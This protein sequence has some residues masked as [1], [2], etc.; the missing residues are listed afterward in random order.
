MAAELMYSS[1]H[2]RWLEH[3]VIPLSIFLLAFLPRAIYPV[4][5]SMLWYERAVHF[6]DALL[7]RDWAGTYLTYH[8]GVTT[9]WLAGIGIKI[10]AWQR[11]LSS[12]QLLGTYPSQI[13]TVNGAIAA[14]VLPLALAI[15][16]CIALSY[17][18]LK[19]VADPKVAIVGSCLLALDPFHITYSKVLHVNALLATF[20]FTSVLYLFSYCRRAKW[21][22]LVLSGV[23]AGLAFLTKSPSFFLMPYVVLVLGIRGL[24]AVGTDLKARS[25]WGNWRSHLWGLIR[26]LLVWI[27]TAAVIFVVVWPA[28]WVKPLDVLSEMANWTFFHVETIHENPIF[29]NGEAEFGDPGVFFYLATIAWKTTAVTLLMSCAALVFA[30]PWFRQKWPGDMVWLLIA[31]VVFFVVQ[32]NLGSWKQVSYMV[33]VFP[34]IGVVA[35][36]GL[37]QS[38]EMIDRLRGERDRRR[39]STLFVLLA[40]AFQFGIVLSHHPY[41]GTHHNNLL[42]GSKVARHI[43]PLQ[44]QGEGLDLAARYLNT[45]PRAQHA[46]AMIYLLGAIPFR[47]S[48]VGF[49]G[50]GP[51]PWI[52]YRIYYVNQ[53]M[54]HLGGE[55]WEKAWNADRQNAPLWSVA[56]DGVTYVWVYGT[57]PGELALG[58]PEYDVSYRLGEHITLERFRLSSETL[59]PGSSLTVV[60]I[61]KTDQKIPEN[62]MVFC[63]VTSTKGELVAQRDGPPIYGVRP[64]P[65]WRAGEVIEDSYEIFLGDDLSP[66]EYELSVG[67]YA[68]ESMERLPAYDASGERLPEDRILLGSLLVQALDISNESSQ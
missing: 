49:T 67:M 29:F 55:E 47:R 32:M 2:L 19:R 54:R 31:Y 26:S 36:L 64:T 50:T 38:A 7:A 21:L 22:D 66:G 24:V 9:M 40:L 46:R 56:F 48:F 52:N 3:W 39:V 42:G 12:A 8:P 43:L 30:L 5:L 27:G 61:W 11:G 68:P 53:V 37:V 10:F 4:S 41:Y 57:P 28:M 20:M 34:A 60:L 62:Y 44:D 14:G 18:L 1:R 23:F 45:L 65:S 16:L 33:P 25:G 17:S 58:G 13:G 63:H 15:A 51:D 59:V 6:G 35:A